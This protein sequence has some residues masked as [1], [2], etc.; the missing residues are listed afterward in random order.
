MSDLK[1][2]KFERQR[3]QAIDAL[4]QLHFDDDPHFVLM[5]GNHDDGKTF[6][7]SCKH[8]VIDKASEVIATVVTSGINDDDL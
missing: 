1:Q 8:W 7:C 3:A 2:D 5:V 4:R 6:V